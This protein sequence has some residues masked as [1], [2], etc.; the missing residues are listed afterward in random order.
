MN[1]CGFTFAGPE[2]TSSVVVAWCN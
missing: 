1:I 2:N